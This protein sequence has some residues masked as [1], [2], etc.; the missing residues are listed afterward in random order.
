MNALLLAASDDTKRKRKD[1]PGASTKNDSVKYSAS[2]STPTKHFSITKTEEDQKFTTPS[3]STDS[4][5]DEKSA[6]VTPDVAGENIVRKCSLDVH[7]ET[8]KDASRFDQPAGVKLSGEPLHTH[9]S[10]E[11]FVQRLRE[12][13]G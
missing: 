5:L 13:C 6:E 1:R 8:Q 3:V 10:N 11:V 9:T 12:C 7:V 2:V 4:C